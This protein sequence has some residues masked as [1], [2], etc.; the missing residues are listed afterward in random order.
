MVRK[1]SD[2]EDAALL[3]KALRDSAV[4]DQFL[5]RFGPFVLRTARRFVQTEQ[6]AEDVTQ[7]VFFRV[8][9]SG[10]RFRGACSVTTW[11]YRITKNA[12]LDLRRAEARAPLTA[13]GEEPDAEMADPDPQNDPE[14]EL[15]RRERADALRHAIT[16]LPDEQREVFLLR[17]GE[18]LS[19]EEIAERVPCEIGTVRSRLAR[20]RK[21]LCKILE[22]GNFFE[23]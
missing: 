1:Q 17:E 11:L 7:T 4:F 8:F 23:N 20:A 2:T 19:Y 3:Q 12:A 13:D 5:S 18:G 22:A 21:K 14:R 10:E 16:L 6:D 15:L 9:R